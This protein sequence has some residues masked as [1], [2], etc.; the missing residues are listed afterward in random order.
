MSPFHKGRAVGEVGLPYSL[1]SC[2]AGICG[3]SAV[4]RRATV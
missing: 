1:E 3:G 2:G 4:G